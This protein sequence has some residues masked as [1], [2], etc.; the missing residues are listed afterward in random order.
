[1]NKF[2]LIIFV[3]FSPLLSAYETDQLTLPQQ[4]L[5]DIGPDIGRYVYEQ[6]QKGL[7][8]FNQDYSGE[9]ESVEQI[10]WPDL[11]HRLFLQI[12]GGVALTEKI[13]SW[14][15]NAPYAPPILK[16]RYPKDYLSFRQLPNDSI[17]RHGTY[18]R[19]L[20][21]GYKYL[22]SATINMY[23]VSLGTDKI[24]H[25]FKQGRQYFDIYTDKINQG[26]RAQEAMKMAAY[27][28]GVKTEDSY[29]G[30]GLSG[31]FSNADLF[32]NYTGMKFY[33]NLLRPL[34]IGDRIYPPILTVSH[35][36]LVFY[37][38]PDNQEEVLMKRFIH[39]AMNEA[40]NPSFYDF[41]LERA[42]KKNMARICPLWKN[43]YPNYSLKT[44]ELRLNQIK[45]WWGE[46]YGHSL[47]SHP[48]KKLITVGNS[49]Y[50]KN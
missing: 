12:G 21:I 8:E 43:S 41:I 35:K 39:E 37:S 25:F 46:D 47:I 6:I 9:L 50:L 15:G 49:C 29:F 10:F 36:K 16:N 28:R 3:L 22:F 44:E 17:Y 20:G 5:K 26:Y 45:K 33:L 32:T 18:H 11:A 42:V 19:G 1:M 30:I 2:L 4:K 34:K 24:G 13:E 23:G 31:V 48:E 27:E 7:D 38:H 14:L 40:F